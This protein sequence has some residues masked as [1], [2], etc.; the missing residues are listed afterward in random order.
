MNRRQILTGLFALPLLAPTPADAQQPASLTGAARA[1]AL[2][3]ANAALNSQRVIQGRFLQI[4]PDGLVTA[5]RFFLQRPGRVRFEYDPPTRL[6][7]VSDGT[8]VAVHDRALRSLNTARLR[9]TPLYFVLKNDINLERDAH[10]TRAIR[11]GDALFV[12]ARDRRGEADGEITLHLAGPSLH[13]RAWDVVDATGGRTRITLTDI[14]PVAALDQRLFR[15][16]RPGALNT[17]APR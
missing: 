2:R 13:L 5:G 12:S 15:V 10:V 3:E 17:T 7:I 14:Q 9:A 6:L 16:P 8:T 11:Q 1:Q 4:A